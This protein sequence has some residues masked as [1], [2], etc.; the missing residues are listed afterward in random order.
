MGKLIICN[1]KH[2]YIP[3]YFKITNT[4]VYSIEELCYYVYNNMELLNEDFFGEALILWLKDELCLEDRADKLREIKNNKGSLKEYAV[5]ILCSSDYYTESEIKRF[6]R[7]LDELV[8]LSP[9]EKLKKKGDNCLKYRQF[10]EAAAVYEK[11]LEG[12]EVTSLSSEEYG[13]L[14]HNLA[15][16]KLHM[17]GIAEAAEGF[18]EAYERNKNPE[19]LK[20]YLM[21]LKLSKQEDILSEEAKTYGVTEALKDEI[22]AEVNTSLEEAEQTEE[23]KIVE[24]FRE[25]KQTGKINQL[26]RIADE[27]INGWKQEFRREHS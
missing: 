11:I 13:N 8:N 16:I 20:Q 19:S 10:A 4:K 6:I 21:A 18:K 23:Y 15:I 7:N 17:V 9:Y 1:G 2:A 25:C 12:E 22:L 14:L 3:Y 5:S 26:Y 24:E 27:L